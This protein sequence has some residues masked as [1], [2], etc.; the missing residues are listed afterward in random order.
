MATPLRARRRA[1]ALFATAVVGALSLTACGGSN[2]TSSAGGSG[3]SAEVVAQ[4]K[5][6]VADH[7][8]PVNWPVPSSPLANP[9][10]ISGK[11]VAIIPLSDKIPLMHGVAQGMIEALAALGAK[12]YICDGGANPSVMADCLKTAGDRGAAVAVPLFMDYE[13]LANAID[14]LTAR[15]VKVL[16]GGVAPSP[17]KPADATLAYADNT[18]FLNDEYANV[19]LQAINA[20]GADTHFLVGNLQDS[21]LTKGFS[22]AAI[23]KFKQLCP[24]C[25]V[26]TIDFT[27][28][29]LDK[30][31]TAI[32]AA[33]A[34]HPKTNVLFIPPDSFVAPA[35]QGVQAAGFTNKLKIVGTG[36]DPSGLARVAAGSETTSSGMSVEFEGWRMANS[37]MQFVSGDPVTPVTEEAD[38]VFTQ[39]NVKAL[40]T[41]KP[42]DYYTSTWFGDDSYK[43]AFLKSWGK[44]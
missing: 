18:K 17:N 28:S 8:T 43:A 4:A 21:S 33:L 35:L 31:P 44:S 22:A 19:A 1:S 34:A 27:S 9:A 12:G 26:N 23:D 20:G 37:L 10:D 5:A 15:G 25:E 29:A 16:L 2:S 40:G 38:R 7:S 39:E 14:A 41:I 3:A 36:A 13:P 24:T 11:T 42:D 30:L 32:S 6:F